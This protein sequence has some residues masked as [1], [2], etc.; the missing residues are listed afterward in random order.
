[1]NETYD[2]ITSCPLLSTCEGNTENP[3]NYSLKGFCSNN[4]EGN[5]CSKCKEGFVEYQNNCEK[6]VGNEVMYTKQIVYQSAG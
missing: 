3:S 1:M 2:V 4:S 6:C 5:L